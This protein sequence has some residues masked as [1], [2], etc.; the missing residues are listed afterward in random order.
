MKYTFSIIVQAG[1]YGDEARVYIYVCVG[2]WVHR[3]YKL[4]P[5]LVGVMN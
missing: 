3:R 5:E 2:G 1:L 4:K